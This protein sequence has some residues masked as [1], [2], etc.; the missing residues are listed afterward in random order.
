M[1]PIATFADRKPLSTPK[2][3]PPAIC[4]QTKMADVYLCVFLCKAL[5][6]LALEALVTA[7]WL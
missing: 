2:V 3:G 5:M 6:G 4:H 7:K 1:P